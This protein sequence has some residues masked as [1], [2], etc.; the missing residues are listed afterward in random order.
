[1]D[2]FFLT[3]PWVSPPPRRQ[4]KIRGG[5]ASL[6][7]TG[8]ERWLCQ[9]LQRNSNRP[10][11]VWHEPRQVLETVP[12]PQSLQT[13]PRLPG[14][15]VLL[16]G[17]RL[18]HDHC[19]LPHSVQRG[20]RVPGQ[21]RGRHPGNHHPPQRRPRTLHRQDL[22]QKNPVGDLQPRHQPQS[23]HPRPLLLLQ[24]VV[25]HGSLVLGPPAQHH[26]HDL[27]LHDWFR[28]SCLDCH[29]RNPAH[30]GRNDHLKLWYK[31]GL[32]FSPNFTKSF[33][34]ISC[35]LTACCSKLYI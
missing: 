11:C 33:A 8:K 21:P 24:A 25:S 17:D 16:P 19:L 31:I 6:D 26:P 1:M 27:Q 35:S 29:G 2:Q 13:S 12:W 7:Q 32:Y 34:T 9:V 28:C 3:L 15:H 5:R 14:S 18:Q 10:E 20:G 23:D 30:Q 4:G 22:Q